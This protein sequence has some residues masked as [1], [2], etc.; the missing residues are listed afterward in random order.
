MADKNYHDLIADTENTWAF[1]ELIR[2]I[3]EAQ[4]HSKNTSEPDERISLPNLCIADYRHYSK[5]MNKEV[6][7]KK[8]RIPPDRKSHIDNFS[9]LLKDTEEDNTET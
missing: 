3:Q 8:E 2:Q 9:A 5:N 7:V 1:E 4:A 6:S